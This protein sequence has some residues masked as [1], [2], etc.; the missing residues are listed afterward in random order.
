MNDST[1]RA[2]MDEL[3]YDDILLVYLLVVDDLLLLVEF[4]LLLLLH[5]MMTLNQGRLECD[6]SLVMLVS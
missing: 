3:I 1:N 6:Q 4:V 5:C 2:V